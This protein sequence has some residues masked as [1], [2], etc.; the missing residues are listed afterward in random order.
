MNRRA[1]NKFRPFHGSVLEAL[2]KAYKLYLRWQVRKATHALLMSL[3]D[4]VLNDIG[5]TRTGA[6]SEVGYGA[7]KVSMNNVSSPQDAP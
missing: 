3:D 2:R 5:I 6:W 7:F 1:H 4:R